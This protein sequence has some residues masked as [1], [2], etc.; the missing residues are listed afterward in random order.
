MKKRLTETDLMKHLMDNIRDNIYFMDR[1]GR[2]ILI[3]KEGTKWLGYESPED[4]IGMT[5]L[6]IFTDEHGT[7]AYEDEQQIMETGIP[8]LGKEEKETWA[9]GHESWVS[10]S[11]MALRTDAGDIVGT[12]GISRDITEHKNAEIRAEK[13]AEENRKFREEMEAELLL[14]AELQKSFFPTSYPLFTKG[15]DESEQVIEFSHQQHSSGMVGGD[16][17]SIRKL[18]ETEVGMLL[19]DVMGHGVRAALGTAIVRGVIEDISDDKKDPG[20]FLSHLNR[21]LMPILRKGDQFLFATSCYMVLDVSTGGLRF[22]N[23]GHSLPIILDQ[24]GKS[25]LIDEARVG[26][27]LAIRADPEYETQEVALQSG[28]VVFTFTDGINEAENS[29]GE[30]FGEERLL[31]AA[32]R[33]IQLPLADYLRTL[34]SEA[35][36]FSSDGEFDDDVCMV[37]FRMHDFLYC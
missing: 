22:A 9:D 13:L 26:P 17:C 16:F 6:D 21:V 25:R 37:G 14:A 32:K 23:A 28:D 24:N 29:S 8:I 11:K 20:E 10:T 33:H 27:A 15:G 31:V 35:R 5:D 2:I 30:E 3:N 4:L 19:C 7:A 12:F 34:F 18:S 36:Q 1:E